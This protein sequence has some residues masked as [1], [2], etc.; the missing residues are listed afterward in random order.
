MFSPSV[1]VYKLTG[2]NVTIGAGSNG[3]ALVPVR[4]EPLVPVMGS[5][6]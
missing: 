2:T 3:Y 4:V 5:R 6:T 1:P